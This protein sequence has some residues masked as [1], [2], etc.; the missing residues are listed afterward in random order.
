MNNTE[1]KYHCEIIQDLLPLYQD[2]ICSDASKVMVEEHLKECLSC[3]IILEKL[4]NTDL[5]DRLMQE[6]Y[7]VLEAHHK[8]EKR[9]TFMIGVCISCILMIPVIICLICNLAIGHALDWFFIVLASL[10]LVASLSVVPLLAPAKQAGLWT[11]VSFV[12]SLLLLLGVICIYVHG[13]WFFL[14]TIPTIFGLSV[15]LMPYVVHHIPL[16]EPFSHHKGLLVMLWDTFWLYA[17]IIVCGFHSTTIDYWRIA[18][19]ITTF[20]IILPWALFVIIRY[21]KVHPLTKAGICSIITGLFCTIINDVILAI[22]GKEAYTWR[23]SDVNFSNWNYPSG[24]A[25]TFVILF[26]TLT[27]IG[28]VLI[29]VGALMQKN[30]KRG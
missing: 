23:L 1:K 10:L 24:Q 3:R 2:N 25:N 9:R 6:K 8:H 5:D 14:A 20:C 15:I 11:I 30:K 4:K 7:S 27:V 21:F 12:G 29:G 26:L 17:I 13:H 28:L 16:S 18:L 22:I 19:Q